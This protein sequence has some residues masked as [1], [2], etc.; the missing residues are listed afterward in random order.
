MIHLNYFRDQQVPGRSHGRLHLYFTPQHGL[1][2]FI[3]LRFVS[4]PQ[5]CSHPG[6]EEADQGVSDC[7]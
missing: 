2:L 7:G 5:S 1:G 4:L 6:E 3:L